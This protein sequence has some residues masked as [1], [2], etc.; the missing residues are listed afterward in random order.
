MTGER[1][2]DLHIAA[3]LNQRRYKEVPQHVKRPID[4]DALRVV[5]VRAGLRE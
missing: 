4:R 2:R 3:R 1:L 5:F